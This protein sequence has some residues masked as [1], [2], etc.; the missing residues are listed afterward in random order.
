M[1]LRAQNMTLNAGSRILLRDFN[2]SFE[3][4]ELWAVLGQNGSGKTTLL[5]TLAGLQ[6][7]A[8]GTVT[9]H[10][11][12]LK[13]WSRRELARNAGILLQQEN[14]MFWG[15]VREYVALGRFPHDD[16]DE[17]IVN[18]A[19]AMCD[20]EKLATHAYQTLSGGERQRT[21]LAQLYTQNAGILLLDEP[22][23]HLDL[24]HQQ[25]FFAY[26]RHAAHT[27]HKTVVMVLH[28]VKPALQ[29]DRALLLYGDG[30]FR[31]MPASALTRE[32]LSELY[33]CEVQL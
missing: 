21:R 3:R 17:S 8:L 1:T 24:K 30:G 2:L 11:K 7:P 14:E 25:Q 20:L 12:P 28:D 27:E 15:S 33:A 10:D 19:L 13:D 31:A 29:C 4:G 9:L 16:E 22:T 5:Q 6:M 23:Q 26:A 18:A 32:I